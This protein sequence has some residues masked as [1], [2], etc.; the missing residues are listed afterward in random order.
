[1]HLFGQ[2]LSKKISATKIRSH[3]FLKFPTLDT[4]FLIVMGIHRINIKVAKLFSSEKN[5][6]VIFKTLL[7]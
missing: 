4:V 3:I 7:I 2:V 5:H 1:M 6:W